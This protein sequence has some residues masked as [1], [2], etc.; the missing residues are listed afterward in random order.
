MS[1]DLR[2]NINLD[3]KNNVISKWHDESHLNRYFLNYPPK[4]LDPSYSNPEAFYIPFSKKII[5]IDKNKLGGHDFLR[6]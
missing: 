1:D 5:Q 3:L 6:S 2:N 4:V